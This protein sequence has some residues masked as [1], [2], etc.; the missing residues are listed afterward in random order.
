MYACVYV[1]VV[2]VSWRPNI[3]LG[4]S[5]FFCNL[6]IFAVA[7]D[8]EF[9]TFACQDVDAKEGGGEKDEEKTVGRKGLQK[10][11]HM[12]LRVGMNSIFAEKRQADSYI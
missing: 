1:V 5:S 12:Y 10:E 4:L 2:I 3:P 7:M 11:T 6:M 9:D 8:T